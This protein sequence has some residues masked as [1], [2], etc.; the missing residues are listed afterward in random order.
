M[1]ISVV[2]PVSSSFTSPL[3]SSAADTWCSISERDTASPFSFRSALISAIS[4]AICS[5]SNPASERRPASASMPCLLMK[6]DVRS[7]SDT[8]ISISF[9]S[10]RKAFPLALSRLIDASDTIFFKMAR[11]FAV[12]PLFNFPP[13][14]R[15]DNFSWKR[16]PP[17]LLFPIGKRASPDESGL[18]IFIIAALTSK[19]LNC[20]TVSPIMLFTDT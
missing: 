15:A 20:I 9:N 19:L 12:S 7:P 6:R 8:I 10:S 13:A 14:S 17:S 11:P 2:S 3:F 18:S 1:S 16:A 5:L 4:S